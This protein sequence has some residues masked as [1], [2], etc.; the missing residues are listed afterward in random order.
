MRESILSEEA[1]QQ[2][3][4]AYEAHYTTKDIIKPSH[5]MKTLWL[6]IRIPKRRDIQDPKSQNIVNAVVPKKKIMDSLMELARIHFDQ[7]V[8]LDADSRI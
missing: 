6:H 5:F 3:A 2:Y 4:A 8:P 7:N 1:G